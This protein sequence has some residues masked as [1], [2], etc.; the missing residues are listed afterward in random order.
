HAVEQAG[1]AGAEKAGQHRERKGRAWLPARGWSSGRRRIAHCGACVA[2]TGFGLGFGFGLAA[3][4]AVAG[5]LESGLAGAALASPAAG[6]AAGGF[7]AV[8]AAGFAAGL[9]AGLESVS[10]GWVEA[11]CVAGFFF[12][13]RLGFSGA[14]ASSAGVRL[15]AGPV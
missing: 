8:L 7:A 2:A 12:A 10:A 6:L 4:S 1:L 15:L 9:A 11:A 5:L 3:G 14:D 13:A